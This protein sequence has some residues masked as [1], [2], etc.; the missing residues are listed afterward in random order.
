M[1][2]AVDHGV[3]NLF[4]ANYYLFCRGTVDKV[5]IL[6]SANIVDT[7][8][9]CSPYIATDIASSYPCIQG[10]PSFITIDLT[11]SNT[12]VTWL[13]FG[14]DGS[15]VI[16]EGRTVIHT[17][18]F[19][20]NTKISFEVKDLGVGIYSITLVADNSF[21]HDVVSTVCSLSFQIK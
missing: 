18:S 3:T 19:T 12:N 14:F 10:I 6:G 2:N 21:E 15:A 13:V 1:N 11:D 4:D 8:P 7:H 16:K 17:L 5:P 20:N 9:A